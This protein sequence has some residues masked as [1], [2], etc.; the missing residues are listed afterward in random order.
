MADRSYL[1][2]AKD[3]NGRTIVDDV[4]ALSA[5][6]AMRRLRQKG[7][8][9]IELQDDDLVP[10][11]GENQE[12]SADVRRTVSPQIRLQ[13]NT[14][15]PRRAR[16][17]TVVNTYRQ[18]YARDLIAVAI[19]VGRRCLNYPFSWIDYLLLAFL[20]LPL[21]L[22]FAL[23]RSGDRYFNLQLAALENRSDDVLK[24]VDKLE[25]T[26][27]KL[28]AHGALEAATWR[29]KALARLG[30]M[31][32]ALSMMERAKAQPG[33]EPATYQ[34]RLA[35]VYATAWDFANVRKCH[36][37]AIRLAPD[38]PLGYLGLAEVLALRFNETDSA[39]Q[40]LDKVRSFTLTPESERMLIHIDGII[41]LNERRF[42]DARR[43]FE[44][45]RAD[46]AER[47]RSV[48]LA[49]GV[50]RFSEALL[51]MACAGGGD[52]AAAKQ[53]YSECKDFLRLHQEDDLLQRCE[54]ALS[55]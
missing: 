19:L 3:A 31:D 38:Q 33:L 40:A 39:R 45:M 28:G 50:Q 2:R 29:A 13:L 14:A 46:L 26:L 8:T 49:L 41:A 16:W 42:D 24:L 37:E 48:P 18:G 36:E 55:C 47:A 23:T 43:S 22:V 30:R 44:T 17:L 52:H 20:A 51:T 25:P 34:N 27:R 32:E 15:T 9:A 35:G 5:D 6:D 53:Y 7:Y 21:L 54:A 10:R 11:D 1:F 12:L 4:M